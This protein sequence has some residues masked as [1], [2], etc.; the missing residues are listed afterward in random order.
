MAG[1]HKFPLPDLWPDSDCHRANG[2]GLR[3]GNRGGQPGPRPGQGVDPAE[4]LGQVLQVRPGFRG[5]DEDRVRGQAAVLGELVGPAADGPGYRLGQQ[6][7]LGQRLGDLRVRG[8]PADPGGVP[9]GGARGDAGLA[10]QPGPRA[11]A[12]GIGPAR[13]RAR[14]EPTR[15][16]RSRSRAAAPAPAGTA[17]GSRRPSRSRRPRPGIPSRTSASPAPRRRCA[18]MPPG[19]S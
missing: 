15:G 13:G 3:P 8:G 17:P 2:R 18:V 16:P 9:G 12:R 10:D 6:V 5:H 14:R 19:S 4:H 11:E 1:E 7:A